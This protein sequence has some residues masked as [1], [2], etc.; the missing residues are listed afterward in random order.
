VEEVLIMNVLKSEIYCGRI[1]AKYKELDELIN[2]L[3]NVLHDLEWWK[4]GDITEESFEKSWNAFKE[5][6]FGKDY[7]FG[8]N[9]AIDDVRKN[10]EK[11]LP[12][13]MKK[14]K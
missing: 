8:Y 14:G 7:V 13:K 12:F 3:S 9:K 11:V 6:W 4:S 5:K 10:I 2:D 1:D